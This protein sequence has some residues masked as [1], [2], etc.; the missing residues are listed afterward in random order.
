MKIKEMFKA[1]E[2]AE[3]EMDIIDAKYDEEPENEEVEVAWT[4]AYEKE[5]EAFTAVVNE[6]VKIS[7]G[8]IDSKTAATTIRAKREEL[9]NL[10]SRIA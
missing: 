9:K 10:I 7:N 5:H 2:A 6:I 4:K 1:L 8:M 3:A